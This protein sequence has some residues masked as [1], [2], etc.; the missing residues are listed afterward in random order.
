MPENLKTATRDKSQRQYGRN[1][2]AQLVTPVRA[3]LRKSRLPGLHRGIAKVAL[4][5]GDVE[6]DLDG[7]GG[8]FLETERSADP[9]ATHAIEAITSA[10]DGSQQGTGDGF[11]RYG[12]TLRCNQPGDSFAEAT[13]WTITYVIDLA[14]PPRPER[15]INR[16]T[17]IGDVGG[18]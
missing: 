17:E 6:R 7:A 5:L 2:P 1:N 15:Q 9:P 11:I 18:G 3:K 8:V 13:R 4:C 10:R 12:K 16:V 14:R